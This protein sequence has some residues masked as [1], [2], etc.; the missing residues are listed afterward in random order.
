[1]LKVLF[2][3]LNGA[4]ADRDE[5]S[6][7]DPAMECLLV[8]FECAFGSFGFV[9]L[10]FYLSFFN[11]ELLGVL[12]ARVSH[13]VVLVDCVL[14]QVGKQ[15]SVPSEAVEQ[16]DVCKYLLQL[17]LVLFALVF[18]MLTVDFDRQGVFEEA[19]RVG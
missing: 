13:A 4:L 14:R 10:G 2:L 5:P 1:M 16:I 8:C 9:L 11:K 6:Q 17:L 3:H 19:L 12:E 18:A 7:Y 15:H